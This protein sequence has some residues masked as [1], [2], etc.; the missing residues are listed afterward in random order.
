MMA[1]KAYA[2]RGLEKDA[3][4]GLS[5]NWF[6]NRNSALL[7]LLFCGAC[8][9]GT[10]SLPSARIIEEGQSTSGIAWVW[11]QEE[12]TSRAEDFVFLF[13]HDRLRLGS[14]TQHAQLAVKKY[15]NLG[16]EA[17]FGVQLSL[18]RVGLEG[19]RALWT[20]DDQAL[21]FSL[22]LAAPLF[23][24]D[25]P[26]NYSFGTGIQWSYEGFAPYGVFLKPLV[27]LR[28]FYQRFEYF[29]GL[30]GGMFFVPGLGAS[31]GP[32]ID[33]GYEWA[34]RPRSSYKQHLQSMELGWLWVE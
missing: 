29:Y 27:G 16:K 25:H 5:F 7:L 34:Q 12:E 33:I 14:P 8:V 19:R 17:D 1:C 15:W 21:A 23:S 13:K 30:H 32:Y 11:L 18:A 3:R 2:R 9:G 4:I 6:S 10:A 26:R 28:P 20:N 31:S 22:Q 24:F